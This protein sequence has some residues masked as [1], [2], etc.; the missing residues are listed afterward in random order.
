MDIFRP[1]A[2]VLAMMATLF[3]IE[4]LSMAGTR[5]TSESRKAAATDR[6]TAV[7]TFK[8]YMECQKGGEWVGCFSLLSSNALQIW[9]D[10]HVRTA[11]EYA[12]VKRTEERGFGDFKIVNTKQI[13]NTIILRLKINTFGE[14][15]DAVDT[16]EFYLVKEK[17]EWKIDKMTEDKYTCL[18]LINASRTPQSYEGQAAQNGLQQ[19]RRELG[20]RSL[21]S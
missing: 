3:L 21:R 19:G 17:G 8:N 5:L 16:F 14:G 9:V 2:L 6:D 15:G 4:P 20:P 18:P 7:L 1:H 13:G 10:Q 11:E 12:A